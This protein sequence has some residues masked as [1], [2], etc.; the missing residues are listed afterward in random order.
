MVSAFDLPFYDYGVRMYRSFA[1]FNPT[2]PMHFAH[3]RRRGE[4]ALHEWQLAEL[5]RLGVR[6]LDVAGEWRVRPYFWDMLLAPA[7]SGIEWDALMW[8]DAD[9]MILRPL[10]PAW[11]CRVDFAGHPDRHDCGLVTMCNIVGGK[12]IT[13]DANPQHAKFATGLWVCRSRKLLEAMR[14]YVEH[15]QPPVGHLM[16]ANDSDAVTMLVNAGPYTYEQLNGYEWNFSRAMIPKA[17][18]RDG[19]ITYRED[20]RTWRPYTAGFSRVPVIPRVRDIRLGSAAL[21]QF[22]REVVCGR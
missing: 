22:Y 5:A 14:E 9:T 2:V 8:I 15:K 10:D 11:K 3:F 4:P 13:T 6:V 21:D 1:R 7:F 19:Q 12:V 16:D 17:R 20:G 18:Y